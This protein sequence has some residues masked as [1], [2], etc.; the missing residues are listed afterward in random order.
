MDKL[1]ILEQEFL[2]KASNAIIKLWRTNLH[3]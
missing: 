2:A 1:S 3:G